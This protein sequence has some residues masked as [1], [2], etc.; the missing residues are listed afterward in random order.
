MTIPN[1]AELR[2]LRLDDR[3]IE[4]AYKSGE[5]AGMD[6]AACLPRGSFERGTFVL[7]PGRRTLIPT[8][9]ILAI[10]R[11]YEGQVR[12]RSGLSTKHGI[13]LPNAVG[14]IDSDYRGEAFV[15]MIN[16][17]QDPFMIEHGMRVAQLVIAP[18]THVAIKLVDELEQ[19]DRGAGGFGST[20][21]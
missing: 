20:G 10:P 14:T 11:G 2:L 6:L 4:P 19:T 7:E 12:P 1:T 8:G 17:S 3:A 16:L 18:V 5:A 15:P 21:F 13:T 9:W